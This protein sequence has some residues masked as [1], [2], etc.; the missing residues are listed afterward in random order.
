MGIRDAFSVHLFR[1]FIA[2]LQEILKSNDNFSK[3]RT[4]VK[5]YARNREIRG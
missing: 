1:N 2:I 4:P 5:I 3:I